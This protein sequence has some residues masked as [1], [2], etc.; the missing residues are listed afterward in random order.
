MLSAHAFLSSL[1]STYIAKTTGVTTGQFIF[2][3]GFGNKGSSVNFARPEILQHQGTK[4][5]LVLCLQQRFPL[6]WLQFAHWT[7]GT[8]TATILLADGLKQTVFSWEHM[9]F[10]TTMSL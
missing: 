5:E 2:F 7:T 10:L 3:L 8:F 9:L 6:T 1:N 4:Q